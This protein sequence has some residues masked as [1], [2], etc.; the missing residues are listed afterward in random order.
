LHK[1]L[2]LGLIFDTAG[3]RA[4]TV[5]F[6]VDWYF[7]FIIVSTENVTLHKHIVQNNRSM[8]RDMLEILG[9]STLIPSQ[10]SSN[11]VCVCVCVCETQQLKL[12]F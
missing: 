2:N 3:Y 8:F 4:S 11:G 6:G 9:N 7:D 5:F 10:N 12:H 1:E